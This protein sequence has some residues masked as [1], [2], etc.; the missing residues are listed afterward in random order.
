MTYFRS[1]LV[2]ECDGD[3][4]RR[5]NLIALYMILEN[6]TLQESV[7][8]LHQFLL[9]TDI[10]VLQIQILVV[11]LLSKDKSISKETQQFF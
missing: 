2:L 1:A 4:K 9:R 5:R 6:V 10:E 3:L 7:N 8:K 11:D